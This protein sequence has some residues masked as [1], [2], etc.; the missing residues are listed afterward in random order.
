MMTK[1]NSK[2]SSAA[3]DD[4]LVWTQQPVIRSHQA[5]AFT[6]NDALE[7]RHLHA[8]AV[9]W[10]NEFVDILSKIRSV[11]H[12]VKSGSNTAMQG[13]INLPWAFLRSTLTIRLPQ[14]LRLDPR[15]GMGYL[16]QARDN[17]Q[18]PFALLA[19]DADRQETFKTT[20]TEV[21]RW[22]VERLPRFV[23]NSP[24]GLEAIRKAMAL[25]ADRKAF[26][27][28]DPGTQTMPWPQNNN[29][30]TAR[31]PSGESYAAVVEEL[32]SVLVGHEL[33][34]GTGPVRRVFDNDPSQGRA[35]LITNPI[36]IN[37]VEKAAGAEFSFVFTLH[38]ETVPS[39]G[40]PIV[41]FDVSKR[42]YIRG[43]IDESTSARSIGGHVFVADRPDRVVSFA[44]TRSRPSDR[45]GESVFETDDAFERIA[46]HYGLPLDIVDPSKLT[47]TQFAH[48][49]PEVLVRMIYANG[50]AKDKHPINVGVPERDWLEAFSAASILAHSVGFA[51]F[52]DLHSVRK[53]TS[54]PQAAEYAEEE[55]D[56]GFEPDVIPDNDTL[57]D[58]AE[59]DSLGEAG[60]ES[61]AFHSE[62]NGNLADANLLLEA[63]Q[64][65]A[66]DPTDNGLR[67]YYGVSKTNLKL[68]IVRTKD[69]QT[70]ADNEARRRQHYANLLQANRE[71]IAALGAEQR[72]L[73]LIVHPETFP[74]TINGLKAGNHQRLI[75]D[76]ARMLWG[77]GLEVRTEP[78]PLM[79]HGP[80]RVLDDGITEKALLRPSARFSRREQAWSEVAKKIRDSNRKTFCLIVAP[81]WYPVPGTAKNGMDDRVNKP[82][83]RAAL[84]AHGG[85][86]VQYLVPMDITQSGKNA[87]APKVDDF[88]Q[89]LQ[90]AL[91]DLLLA[92][93]GMVRDWQDRA[94]LC[95]APGTEPREVIG[96]TIVRKQSG[97]VRKVDASFVL[98]AF[99]LVLHSPYAQMRFTY[100][101]T[102]TSEPKDTG[103]MPMQAGL[104]VLAGVTPAWLA[105]SK[106]PRVR[107]TAMRERYQN[108]IKAIMDDCAE[109]KSAAVVMVDSTNTASLWPWITDQK[110][111]ASDI[112]INT[113]HRKMQIEWA[114]LRLVRVRSG[115]APAVVQDKGRFLAPLKPEANEPDLTQ[116]FGVAGTI[117]GNQVYRIGKGRGGITPYWSVESEVHR[118]AR[119][120]SAYRTTYKLIKPDAPASY[121]DW[122]LRKLRV[123]LP[124]IGQWPSPNPVELVVA[125][126]RETD[127]PDR[128]AF[129]CHWLRDHT[130]HVT[131]KTSLPVPLFFERVFREYVADFALADM[132]HEEEGEADEG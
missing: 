17:K 2:N 90:S 85:A 7:P 116:V 53:P 46:M 125:L 79:A 128:L 40:Q 122:S 50:V 6:L 82:A 96:I 15:V 131:R 74:A 33:L 60:G 76:T 75:E 107:Q 69:P 121:G 58:D 29:N 109:R 18:A 24:S 124:F 62:H 108:F 61:S 11:G 132:K 92:H 104:G 111:D 100:E 48:R 105:N 106:D 88:F 44:A 65:G 35:T 20:N 19:A 12:E 97:R 68:K 123:A 30:G 101:D 3:D 84:A 36:L 26:I 87:G 115:L 25:V 95:F 91:K 86:S 10:T 120:Q 49:E 45:K 38:C 98:A 5:M 1:T 55:S 77:D 27:L 70:I 94:A 72:P 56:D 99:R 119:G 8:I 117:A 43:P 59:L 42:R 31:H 51:P 28:S 23:G 67:T 14:M 64:A 37:G 103:W 81:I 110:L 130:T 73:L 129:F 80:S 39:V 13:K 22:L 127:D 9:R 57:H 102:D 126:H 21:R 78:L 89:R 34:P 41:V 114:G 47:Q 93:P 118:A 112:A 63:L 4:I 52:P 71:A 16:A 54:Q 83:A 66:P 32:A 113:A